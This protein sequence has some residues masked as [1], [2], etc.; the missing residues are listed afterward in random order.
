MDMTKSI[1]I[2]GGAS[3][4][5]AATL[6][7][8]HSRGWRVGF[9]DIDAAAGGRL[10]KELPEAVFY[11]VSTCHRAE[12]EAAIADFAANGHG[13]N[14]VFC[15]A[16]VHHSG[17]LLGTSEEDL[18]R[19]VEINLFGTVNTLRA[20]LPHILGTQ[21]GP[22]AV[23]INASDQSIIGKPHSFAYGMCKGALGQLTKSLALDLAKDGVR[24]NAVCPGTIRTPLVDAIFER[25]H[26]QDSSRAIDSFW[27]E[28]ASLFPM[29][30]VGTPD[31]VA[32]GVYYL[33]EEATFTT[34][35]LLSIDGGL[36]A[37]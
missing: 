21:A 23:V 12:L 17:T 31:E 29:Q 11:K 36:T 5:G 35:S 22:R 3:G 9:C 10:L 7:L 26:R 15:N 33:I 8:F 24:V 27:E 2:T 25:C 20:A 16:G 19:V 34:G 1:F 13:L 14:A 32:G 18:R 30:R 28:E 37:G 6:R 4:I